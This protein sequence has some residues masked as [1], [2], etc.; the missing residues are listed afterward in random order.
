MSFEAVAARLDASHQATLRA[1]KQQAQTLL[2]HTPRFRFFTLHGTNHLNNLFEVLE[3]LLRGGITLKRDELFLLSLA[4]CI[5]D[6]G[7]VVSLRD[8]EVPSVLDGRPLATDPAALESFIRETHH[9][10]VDA[11]LQH[12][13]GFL[14]AVGLSPA[15]LGQVVEISRCH[16]KV[17]LQNQHGLI[18]YLGALLRVIDELDLGN[19]R[20][21]ANVF[22]NIVDDMD[23]T[24]CWHWFKHNIIE[25]WAEN[26]TVSFI[27]ENTKRKIEF[28]LAVRPTKEGSIGY[29]LNQIHRPIKKALEDD[30]AGKIIADQFGVVIEVVKNRKL[31]KAH[32][33]GHQWEIIENKAL[34]AGRKVV[35]VIDDE[36][37]KLEDLFFPLMDEYHI[38]AASSAKDAL[39][40]LEATP[41]DLAI[42]DMQI[43]SG[44][45][46]K[47]TETQDFK[48]TGR[49]ICEMIRAQ[50]PKTKIGVLTGT[51]HAIDARDIPDAAFFLRKPT[52]PDKLLET[53]KYVLS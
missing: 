4:I 15:Q 23:A 49:K 9:E 34:S 37:R 26:H 28:Q 1:V 35:L 8:K 5:H 13:T 3:L 30:E 53:V 36:F 14:A 38:V 47:D 43:G 40:K 27:T 22:L 52:D 6:L 31:S 32:H 33:P 51:K 48:A 44:G 17:V 45:L 39:S 12:D 42:V 21:P 2:D 46:W 7:M 19:N 29:W 50:F 18:K 20:A 11:Y 10:L 24:S 41:V 16:R 25:P